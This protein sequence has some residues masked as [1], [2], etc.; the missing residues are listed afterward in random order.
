MIYYSER[1]ISKSSTRKG[2]RGKVRKSQNFQQLSPDGVTLNSS[3]KELSQHL[4]NVGHQGNSWKTPFL[5]N[6]SKSRLP[7][8]LWKFSI[9]HIIP[10]KYLGTV[11][12]CSHF[13]NCEHPP[14]SKFSNAS[15]GPIFHAGI[16][17]DSNLI[18][19]LLTL[20]YTKT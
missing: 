3:S 2:A 12:H 7:E 13:G 8:G 16:S 17:K 14:E 19:V 11:S 18:C 10:T 20:F 1:M 15:Q 9:R 6:M 4:G 5:V